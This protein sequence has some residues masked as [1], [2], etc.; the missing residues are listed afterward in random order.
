MKNLFSQNNINHLI[1]NYKKKGISKDLAER[2]YTSRLLGSNHELVLHG[3][4]NT[5]VKSTI[6]DIDGIN[7]DI[8]YV[9]GS[10]SDLES[11]EPSGFPA[12]KISS[13]L[14]IMNKKIVTQ[15]RYLKLQIDQTD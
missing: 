11:I 10:G 13:L 4:G 3:G 6:K 9:K 8:I 14:K 5:S 7:Y 12:L 1:L 15:L 2:I